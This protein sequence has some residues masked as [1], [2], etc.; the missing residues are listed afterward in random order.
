MKKIK[1]VN[2]SLDDFIDNER[3]LNDADSD[4]DV[5]DEIEDEDSEPIV[6]SPDEK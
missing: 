6:N 1:L 4:I 2:E 3:D 5:A